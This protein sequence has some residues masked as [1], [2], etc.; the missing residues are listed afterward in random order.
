MSAGKGG[1]IVVFN[2][3]EYIKEMHRL[4]SNMDTYAV[5][6]KDPTYI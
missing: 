3:E 4:Q 1:G 5:L 6:K 2:K